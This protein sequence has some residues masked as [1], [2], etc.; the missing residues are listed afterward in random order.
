MKVVGS[1]GGAYY[2]NGRLD[3]QGFRKSSNP[4]KGFRNQI[5]KHVHH[6]QSIFVPP[7]RQ[8]NLHLAS[9]ILSA[10]W[11]SLLIKSCFHVLP[12]SEMCMQLPRRCFTLEPL[13]SPK[14]LQSRQ[15]P[16]PFPNAWGAAAPGKGGGG[17]TSTRPPGKCLRVGWTWPCTHFSKDLTSCNVGL[18]WIWIAPPC[19]SCVGMQRNVSKRCDTLKWDYSNLRDSGSTDHPSS[20]RTGHR[21]TRSFAR[22]AFAALGVGCF[23]NPHVFMEILAMPP[24]RY[25]STPLE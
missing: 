15:T 13:I 25:S 24:K 9:E 12:M 8:R 17:G 3:L 18:K 6:D 11:L 5:L 21:Q 14:E 16:A 4:P 22:S 19:I 23:R 10:G 7:Y 2:F 1:H 20:H